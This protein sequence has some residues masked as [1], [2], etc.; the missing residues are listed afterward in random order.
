MLDMRSIARRSARQSGGGCCWVLLLREVPG[1]GTSFNVC[2][3]HRKL[4]NML[5]LGHSYVLRL[6]S[7]LLIRHQVTWPGSCCERTVMRRQW[8]GEYVRA[9][10]V[11]SAF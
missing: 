4:S 11:Y 10:G 5:Q 2:P 3:L 9:S 8:T 1:Q 6:N 7:L